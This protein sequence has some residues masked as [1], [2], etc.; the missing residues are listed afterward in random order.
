MEFRILASD[1]LSNAMRLTL[2]AIRLYRLQTERCGKHGDLNLLCDSKRWYFLTKSLYS[3]VTTVETTLLDIACL[4]T[5]LV[6]EPF[7]RATG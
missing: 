5:E 1:A 3:T 7:V 6:T 2:L 4:I